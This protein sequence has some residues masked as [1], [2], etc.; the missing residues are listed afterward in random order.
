M[1]EHKWPIRTYFKAGTARITIEPHGYT[2]TKEPLYE[3]YDSRSLERRV[4]PESE[5][6]KE[7]N[8]IRHPSAASPAP[9]DLVCE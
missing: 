5:I 2:E 8:R 6:L 3:F 9:C 7:F 4:L 1:R